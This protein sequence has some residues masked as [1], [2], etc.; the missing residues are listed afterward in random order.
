MVVMY[1]KPNQNKN[2]E[3]VLETFLVFK[4]KKLFSIKLFFGLWFDN[5]FFLHKNQF[6]ESGYQDKVLFENIF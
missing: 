1:L 2:K 4:I 5:F 6:S 3:S